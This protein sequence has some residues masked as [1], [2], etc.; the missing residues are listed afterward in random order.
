MEQSEID[1]ILT[2]LNLHCTIA[3]KHRVSG[4]EEFGVRFVVKPEFRLPMLNAVHIPVKVNDTEVRALLREKYKIEIG[5]GLGPLE[6]KT[7]RIGL[8]GHTA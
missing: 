2:C 5:G 7:W 1:R 8:M 6:G 3:H 4:L